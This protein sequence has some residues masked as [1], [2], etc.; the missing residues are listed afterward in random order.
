MWR[1]T[2]PLTLLWNLC[3]C[4]FGAGGVWGAVVLVDDGL[5]SVLSLDQTERLLAYSDRYH[6]HSQI[7]NTTSKDITKLVRFEPLSASSSQKLAKALATYFGISDSWLN[8]SAKFAIN[9]EVASNSWSQLV[10][11][12]KNREA[13]D[14][15]AVNG[16]H[17]T[18]VTGSPFEQYLGAFKEDPI[19]IGA[20]NATHTVVASNAIEAFSL[21]SVPELTPA[22]RVIV[23]GVTQL[24]Q[25]AVR[26]F[27]K[28]HLSRAKV[29]LHQFHNGLG[30]VRLCRP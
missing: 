2:L 24:E 11:L 14:G 15:I 19:S 13:I 27:Q 7:Q 30:D 18:E 26:A 22:V 3:G 8:P 4:G 23:S 20:V 10:L 21:L 29:R 5:P 28:R 16:N 12:H 25:V 1:P 17:P 9:F 6:L